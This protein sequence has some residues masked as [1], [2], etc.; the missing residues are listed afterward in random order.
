MVQLHLRCPDC[1]I[2]VSA[3]DPA[4]EL[5]GG[6]CPI[7]GTA[8][9]PASSASVVIGYRWLDLGVLGEHAPNEEPNARGQSAAGS[10]GYSG[11]S[12][13]RR[14]SASAARRRAS[15]WSDSR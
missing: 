14:S 5:L 11:G 8:L 13:P 15:A 9:P 2:R 12:V 1:R 4:I 6:C 3:A 7:C 10:G